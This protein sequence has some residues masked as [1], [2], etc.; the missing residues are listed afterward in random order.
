MP[1]GNRV[2]WPTDA[3]DRID[4]RP[5]KSA[6]ADSH[7][8]GRVSGTG[9]RPGG[10]EDTPEGSPTLAHTP[11]YRSR[12]LPPD[13]TLTAAACVP[14]LRLLSG[15]YFPPPSVDRSTTTSPANTLPVLVATREKQGQRHN[16]FC[17]CDDGEPVRFAF[18]CDGERVDG[19]CGCRRS[20]T[21]MSTLKAT[22]TVRVELLPMSREQFVS[23]LKASYGKSGFPLDDG[24]V[25]EEA[26]ELLRLA[27]PFSAGVVIEKRGDEMRQRA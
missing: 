27:L 9:S 21:G 2:G 8:I 26:D 25:K 6:P 1:P 24:A 15:V 14:S 16:D 5:R 19:R 10:S 7:R 13:S 17:W 3:L 18:A 12:C 22:T 4:Y 11:P 20:M 23:V